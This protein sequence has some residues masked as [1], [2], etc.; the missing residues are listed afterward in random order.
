V[1]DLRALAVPIESLKPDPRN[2]RTHGEQNRAAI[3]ASLR[4]NGQQKP[5][6]VDADG[7]IL[8]GNGTWAAAKALG[9]KYIARVRSELTGAR[10][11]AW[12][13]QDNRSAELAEWDLVELEAQLEEIAADL[14]DTDLDALG[15]S[16]E[17][18]DALLDGDAEKAHGFAPKKPP[19][20]VP[21]AGE[22]K[23]PSVFKIIIT[24]KNERDH[25]ELIEEF[26]RRGY[27][28]K[29]PNVT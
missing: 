4:L 18:L 5:I 17:Q 1:P 20:E 28:I 29:S 12:A 19:K 14:N 11:R 22:E 27:E 3:E 26:E 23:Y 9:W 16:D 21:P 2:A 25:A 13:I 24:C 7:V 8:A 6:S 10:A 15:F